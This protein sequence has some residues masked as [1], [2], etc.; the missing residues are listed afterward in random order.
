MIMQDHTA[1]R[2]KRQNLNPGSLTSEDMFST[3]T[4]YHLPA[5]DSYIQEIKRFIQDLK[6]KSQ[7]AQDHQFRLGN[8]QKQRS[9]GHHKASLKLPQVLSEDDEAQRECVKPDAFSKRVE[10][11]RPDR[12]QTPLHFPSCPLPLIC[13]LL[14]LGGF[15]LPK[16]SHI[17]QTV[18]NDSFSFLNFYS[19]FETIHVASISYF[20]SYLKLPQKKAGEGR[21]CL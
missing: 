18:S 8:I 20:V 10:N 14:I 11:W 4:L 17:P 3:I 21:L 19:K 16:T 15:A 2:Q 5:V 1:N 13:C 7:V 9:A 12:S 6:K